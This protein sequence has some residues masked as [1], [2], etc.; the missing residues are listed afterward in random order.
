M[1][2]A[3]TSRPTT[4]N[5]LGN[6]NKHEVHELVRETRNCQIDEIILAGHAVVFSP[7]TLAQAKSEGFDNCDWCLAA[8]T[9]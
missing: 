6:T 4:K 8:S 7:D 9:R 5:F 3:V 2:T 1:A